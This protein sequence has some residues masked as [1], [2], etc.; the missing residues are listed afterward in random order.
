MGE[1]MRRADWR[2]TV[3]RTLA[4]LVLLAGVF[5]GAKLCVASTPADHSLPS[6][7]DAHSTPAES[8]RHLSHFALGVTGLI[9]LVVAP[10]D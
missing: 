3:C 2:A 1:T 8:I 6:I 4:I 5:L 10:E 9:F 7:F